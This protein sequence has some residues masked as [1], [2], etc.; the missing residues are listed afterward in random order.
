MSVSFVLSLLCLEQGILDDISI[1]ALPCAVRCPCA[2]CNSCLDTFFVCCFQAL[3]WLTWLSNLASK[4]MKMIGSILLESTGAE[5]GLVVPW[6]RSQQMAAQ[7][8]EHGLQGHG[9]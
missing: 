1:S 8:V 7:P 2:F 3:C 6:T 4:A 9:E 5:K